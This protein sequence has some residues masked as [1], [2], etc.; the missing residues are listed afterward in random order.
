MTIPLAS[1][2]HPVT[3]PQ[4]PLMRAP[5]PRANVPMIRNFEVAAL[6][7]DDKMHVE[8]H[9]APA[10]PLFDNAFCAFTRG[11]L[12]STPLG[13]VAVEDL[14]PSEALNTSTGEP[15]KILWIGSST[16][17]PANPE[18]RMPLIRIM[19]DT[20]GPSRPSSFLTVGPSA[21]LL[22]VPHHLRGETNG[23]RLFTLASEFIDGVN[24]I[25]V[26]PP[27]PVRMFHICLD[28]QAAINVDGMEMETYHPGSAAIRSVS[29]PMRDLFLSM[30]PH[31]SHARDF[32][33]LAHPR[34]PEAKT[35]N[36]N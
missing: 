19:A 36:V 35:T 17:V 29:H 10:L 2:R 28:R 6:R 22:Q 7:A 21:R 13:D 4:R 8:Q 25:E 30:F 24:V 12:M 15:A 1:S 27:T 16:F 14:Q 33:P 3:T 5:Q 11:S 23:T 26:C 9:Q 34:A 31:I 32:G 18:R 20:F